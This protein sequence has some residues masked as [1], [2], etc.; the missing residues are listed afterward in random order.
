MRPGQPRRPKVVL[1]T[2]LCAQPD[3]PRIVQPLCRFRGDLAAAFDIAGLEYGRADF[4]LVGGRVQ[5]YEINSNPEILFGNDHPS[6]ARQE[7]YRIFRRNYL[8]VL[9]AI[10]TPD[11]AS[12]VTIA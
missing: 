11:A 5:V 1:A 4:G 12:T 10:D 9:S 3:E 2:K 8:D 7:T 6:P